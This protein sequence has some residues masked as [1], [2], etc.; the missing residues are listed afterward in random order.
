MLEIHGISIVDTY[1]DDDGDEAT[2]ITTVGDWIFDRA[3]VVVKSAVASHLLDLLTPHFIETKAMLHEVERVFNGAVGS[4][5][6]PT[7]V[8]VDAERIDIAGS[9]YWLGVI[10]WDT[11][12]ALTKANAIRIPPESMMEKVPVV[13]FRDD[14]PVACLMACRPVDKSTKL[15][16]SNDD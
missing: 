15:E 10:Y 11:I 7:D 13:F 14:K 5:L 12:L 16:G 3:M 1:L 9:R 6:Y 2:A 8:H 4:S